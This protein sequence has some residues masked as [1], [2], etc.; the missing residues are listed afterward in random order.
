MPTTFRK[1]LRCEICD[2]RLGSYEARFWGNTAT[3]TAV[4]LPYPMIEWNAS[5]G[6]PKPQQGSFFGREN[7]NT[8]I[9]LEVLIESGGTIDRYRWR[10]R[11]DRGEV[12]LRADTIAKTW[13]QRDSTEVL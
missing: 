12:V 4:R 2:G 5:Q 3:L 13:S 7:P 1:R 9:P 6:E 11:C 10:C 8:S